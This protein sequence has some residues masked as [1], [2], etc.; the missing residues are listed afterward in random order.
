[1][2]EVNALH[3]FREGNGRNSREFFRELSLN[4]GYLLDWGNADKDKLFAADIS[5]FQQNY[6]PLV[7]LLNAI[8]AARSLPQ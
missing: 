2:G 5:A 3:P 7:A 6:A 1:M 8:V 4:A